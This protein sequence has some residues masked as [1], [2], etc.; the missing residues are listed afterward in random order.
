M[1]LGRK[2]SISNE[3]W[4]NAGFASKE[5]IDEIS[6]QVIAD[7][8]SK[9]GK[10]AYAW[11]GGK[12]SIV[13]GHLCE[14]AGVKDCVLAVTDLEYP[15]F[16]QWVNNNKPEK[17]TIINTGQNLEWLKANQDMLF[18]DDSRITSKWFRIVQHRAQ[19][20]YYKEQGLDMI[21]LGRRRADGNF[22]GRGTNVYESKGVVRYSPISEWTHEEVL[23]YLIHENLPIPPIYSWYNGYKCGTH[24]WPARPYTKGNGWQEV[25]DIDPAIVVGASG[26]I[27]SAKMFLED[28]K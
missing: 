23:G 9:T 5:R 3:D 24:P 1:A 16:V 17:L 12:D 21:L 18:P 6:E 2:Q 11:S 20:K 27:E 26:Y 28:R 25:Y 22:V 15:A 8:K 10:L 7:I 4:L 13:L 14:R 19:N